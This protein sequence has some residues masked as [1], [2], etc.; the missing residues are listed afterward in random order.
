MKVSELFLK[1]ADNL[2]LDCTAPLT[3]IDHGNRFDGK[4]V[5]L[6]RF[7]LSC[8]LSFLSFIISFSNSK[9]VFIASGRQCGWES[10]SLDDRKNA[11]GQSIVYH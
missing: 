11:S 7:L 9:L 6:L 5:G 3:Y 10:A 2:T 4:L 1:V 8:Y